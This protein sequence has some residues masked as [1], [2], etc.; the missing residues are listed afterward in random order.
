MA[1]MSVFQVKWVGWFVK[2]QDLTPLGS[3]HVNDSHFPVGLFVIEIQMPAFLLQ[4]KN[5]TK[6]RVIRA[7]RAKKSQ[8]V[9][10][11][12]LHIIR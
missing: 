1:Q 6:N 8:D 2:I 7:I 11:F 12:P 3:Y 4:Q 9:T 5:K 10:T